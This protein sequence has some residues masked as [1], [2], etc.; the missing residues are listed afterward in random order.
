MAFGI[1]WEEPGIVRDVGC[2]P[3]VDGGN[4]TMMRVIELMAERLE[5]MDVK[6]LAAMADARPPHWILDVAGFPQ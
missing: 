2:V 4:P 3:L 6:R 1:V 5:V